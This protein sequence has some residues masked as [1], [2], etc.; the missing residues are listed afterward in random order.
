MEKTL[1]LHRTSLLPRPLD[2]IVMKSF[3]FFSLNK[4][5]IFN[6]QDGDNF[7]GSDSHWPNK[8]ALGL[9]QL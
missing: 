5:N 2:A 1:S 3:L 7:K 8:A 4:L 6:K 9:K